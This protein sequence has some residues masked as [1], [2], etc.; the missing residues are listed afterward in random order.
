MEQIDI[1]IIIP[2]LNEQDNIDYLIESLSAYFTSQTE[3]S[4]EVL[5]VDDGSTDDSV[6]FLEAAQHKG[7]TPKII[8]LSRNYGA[9]A[10]LRA[11]LLHTKGNF[12][13]C[14][15]ADL[16]DPLPL[17]SELYN[18]IQTNSLELVFA[19]RR[20][21]Q[22]SFS[23]KVFSRLYAYLMR[24]YAIENYPLK[25]FDLVMFGQKVRRELNQNI[26][27]NSSIFL[28][29]LTMGF[30]QATIEYDKQARKVGKSKWTFNK[31]VK[32]FIDS[33]IAFSFA[34][35]RFVTF[36]GILL[37]ILGGLFGVYIVA[38]KFIYNDLQQGWASLIAILMVGFGVTNI[39]LGIIAEYLWRALD[40]SRN[41][42]VFI[43]DDIITPENRQ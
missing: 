12:I 38:R 26:E 41:R 25:G 35:I 19:V 6:K 29:I 33:F 13:V 17:V 43:I 40:A 11:G 31:K 15:P 27:A 16:Q 39:S 22:T 7:Y 9:H 18:Q 37:F 32:L 36:I 24:K 4:V 8:K 23:E 42:P 1:S 14:L 20:S 28:Q 2:F 34:P 21:T 30:R 3:I 5:F 10:A